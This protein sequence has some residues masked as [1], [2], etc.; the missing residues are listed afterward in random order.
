MNFTKSTIGLALA[1]FVSCL[2]FGQKEPSEASNY[3]NNEIK[4]QASDGIPFTIVTGFMNAFGTIANSFS[5]YNETQNKSQ[6]IPH[7]GLGYRYHFNNIVSLGIDVGYQNSIREYTLSPNNNSEPD[8]HRKKI[9]QLFL[10]MPA[11]DFTYLNKRIVKLY[12]G[13]ALGIAIGAVKNTYSG[14]KTKEEHAMG[15]LPAFQLT[16]FGIRVGKEVAGYFEVGL[17]YKGFLTLGLSI[18]L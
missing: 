18:D 2:S 15:Y 17:G 16:P 3:R 6:S 1:L 5:N 4:I 12:G 10:I 7:F 8:I 14:G 9:T 13:A 11:A